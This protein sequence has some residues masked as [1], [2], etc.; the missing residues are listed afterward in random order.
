MERSRDI[1]LNGCS[2]EKVRLSLS[3]FFRQKREEK[4]MTMK[5]LSQRTGI[6]LRN[7][8]KIESGDWDQLPAPIYIRDFLSKCAYAF[9][10]DERIFLD[11][12]EYEVSSKINEKYSDA[13]KMIKKSFIITPKTIAKS[14][15][16]I[17]VCILI[18]Y[19]IFQLNYLL[20]S[21]K[22]IAVSPKN[23]IIT[24]LKEIEISGFTQSENKVSI[25]ENDIFVDSRGFFNETIPLQ[26]GINTINIKATNRLNKDYIIIRRIILEE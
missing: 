22:L 11:I 17:F 4:R 2:K 21:P 7:L 15:F 6:S 5:V 20:G 18:A 24:R 1:N 9:F 12:Y 3:D 13:K 10:E 23:D 16:L 8:E 14:S 19:F 25:N 26:L